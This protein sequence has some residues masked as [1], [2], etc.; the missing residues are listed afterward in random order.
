VQRLRFRNAY[1]TESF[2]DLVLPPDHRPGQQHP[3]VVVQY[4]SDGF[5]RGGTGDEVPIHPLANRGFAVLSFDRPTFSAAAL[6]A[7]S[8]EE[9]VRANR[10]DWI[11]R[12]R[13]QSSL[14]IALELAIETGAVDAGRMGIS[15]FSDGGSTVQW[16]LINSDL[17]KW[18]LWAHAAKICIPIRRQPGPGLQTSFAR[19]A[20][21]TSRPGPKNSGDPCRSSSMSTR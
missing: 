20:T 21:A 13:V 2:A 3:L 6:T 8:E 11:D 17:S 16:A 7:T 18:P 10:A 14:E 12:R 5:L 1:G 15:G 4:T 19:W 9:L